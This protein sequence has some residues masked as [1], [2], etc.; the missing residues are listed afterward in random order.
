VEWSGER[1]DGRDS[2]PTPSVKQ[3]RHIAREKVHVRQRIPWTAW[4]ASARKK[5]A[6]KKALAGREG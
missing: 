5:K 1:A 3:P 4:M 6:A 2:I